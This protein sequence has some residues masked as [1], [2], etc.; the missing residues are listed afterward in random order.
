MNH[1]VMNHPVA[2]GDR[3]FYFDQP[4]YGMVTAFCRTNQ[5]KINTRVHDHRRNNE[6]TPPVTPEITSQPVQKTIQLGRHDTKK[7]ER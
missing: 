7:W 6:Q 1:R 5:R 2:R 3:S 4:V